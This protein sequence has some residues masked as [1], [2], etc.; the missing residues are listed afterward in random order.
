MRKA[1]KIALAVTLATVVIPAAAYSLMR[2]GDEDPMADTLREFGFVRV[3]LPSNLMNLGSLYYVDAGLKDF[4]TTCHAR[5]ADLGEDVIMSRSGD[6][7]KNLERKGALASD[8][9]VDFGSLVKGGFGNDYVHR[10]H[11]SLIDVVVEELPLDSSLTIYSK[12]QIFSA[13]YEIWPP[14]ARCAGA[15]TKPRRPLLARGASTRTCAFPTSRTGSDRIGPRILRGGM[16][17][18][19]LPE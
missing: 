14:V 7:E 17:L 15:W 1:F 4:K 11:F 16:R 6:I 19:G 5:A 9:T 12:L 18:A 8:V 2:P 13:Q 3:P 10:V